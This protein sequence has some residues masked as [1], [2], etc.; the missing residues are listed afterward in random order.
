MKTKEKEKGNV[1]HTMKITR[2]KIIYGC[3]NKNI[4]KGT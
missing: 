2:N 4:K 1:G 3:L